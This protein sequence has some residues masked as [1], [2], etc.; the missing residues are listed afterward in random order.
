MRVVEYPDEI[1]VVGGD[2]RPAPAPQVCP[3]AIGQFREAGAGMDELAAG[4]GAIGGQ[5]QA[6]EGELGAVPDH[7]PYRQVVKT[8]A[9]QGLGVIAFLARRA[10]VGHV[11]P[12]DAGGRV[13]PGGGGI[14]RPE[15]PRSAAIPGDCKGLP[16]GLAA[17]HHMPAVRREH[18]P[19]VVG[20][21]AHNGARPPPVFR[22]Q[23]H[24]DQAA[25]VAKRVVPVSGHLLNPYQPRRS[26]DEFAE[27]Q[28]SRV[29]DAGLSGP[30]AGH[31][32]RQDQGT[33]EKQTQALPNSFH[34][35]SHGD[36]ALSSL[37][38]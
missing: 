36:Q 14:A 15:P 20:D 35:V 26:A 23:A 31:R 9:L 17:V 18:G 32:A 30:R 7:F 6:V 1:A 38:R 22:I 28:S 3:G 33:D 13:L 16:R 8:H 11:D 34:P 29:R 25:A 4:P 19:V 5:L 27:A 10:V 21:G 12:D 37:G 2:G 24:K